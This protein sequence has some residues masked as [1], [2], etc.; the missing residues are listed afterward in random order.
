MCLVL[1]VYYSSAYHELKP[2][3]KLEV[4]NFQ[5]IRTVEIDRDYCISI[6]GI[7]VSKIRLVV[8]I[9]DS[10]ELTRKKVKYKSNIPRRMM[11]FTNLKGLN[12]KAQ[13]NV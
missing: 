3:I 13:S 1:Q 2:S 6:L 7:L 4:S 11:R 5:S 8:S 9:I 10:I 12:G